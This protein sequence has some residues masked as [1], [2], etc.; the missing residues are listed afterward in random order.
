MG[1]YLKR[2][3]IT[4]EEIYERRGKK[5]GIDSSKAVIQYSPEGEFI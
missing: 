1:C 4:Q 2:V 3:G 5:R